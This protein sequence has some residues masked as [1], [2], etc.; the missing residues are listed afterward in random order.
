MIIGRLAVSL[1]FQGQGIG[2][3]LLRDA[4]RRVLRASEIVGCRAVVVHAIDQDAAEFY[5]RFGFVEFPDRSRTMYLSSETL[6]RAL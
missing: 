1:R 3:G 5:S 2:A 6:R 4:F